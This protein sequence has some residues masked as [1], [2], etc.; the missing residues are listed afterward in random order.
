MNTPGQIIFAPREDFWFSD[1]VGEI[2]M[3]AADVEY[4][5]NQWADSRPHDR[6][7]MVDIL[8][9]VKGV[10]L[11]NSDAPEEFPELWARAFSEIVG[12]LLAAGKARAYCMRCHTDIPTCALK[13]ESTGIG[14]SWAFMQ[15][16]CP[17]GHPLV[18]VEAIHFMRKH[19]D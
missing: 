5:I 12:P 1:N 15:S 4:A 8:E 3:A 14:G 11:T 18:T 6:S 10:R 7:C 2:T 9:W 19:N 13:V 17:S 16:R